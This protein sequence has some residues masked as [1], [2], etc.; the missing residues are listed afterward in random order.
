MFQ[1]FGDRALLKNLTEPARQ[2]MTL[3]DEEA[4]ML[5]HQSVGSEHILLGLV[6]EGE[7][8]AAQALTV[9]ELPVERLRPEVAG[10]VR[11]GTEPVKSGKLP[12]GP[13]AKAVLQSAQ[14]EARKLNHSMIGTEHLLLGVVDQKDSVGALVLLKVGL[15][16]EAVRE[17]IMVLLGVSS[18]A[19]KHHAELASLWGEEVHLASQIHKALIQIEKEHNRCMSEWQRALEA[20]DAPRETMLVKELELVQSRKKEM[21]QALDQ[22]RQ[23]MEAVL[24]EIRAFA[25]K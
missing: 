2:V 22:L 20:R 23:R 7:G 11:P 8:I 25:G 18:G 19:Q 6:K 16:L 15:T 24:T 14:D 3:A 5:N 4:R 10:M 17:E 13:S 21:A 9:L 1:F 12:L